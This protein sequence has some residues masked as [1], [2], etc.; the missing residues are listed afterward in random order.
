MNTKAVLKDLDEAQK[1][2]ATPDLKELAE[3]EIP[4]LEKRKEQAG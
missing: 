3:A 4:H 1:M 2:L